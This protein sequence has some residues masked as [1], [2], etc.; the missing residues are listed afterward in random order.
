VRDQLAEPVA[1]SDSRMKALIDQSLAVGFYISLIGP[2]ILLFHISYSGF[3]N[4]LMMQLVA[5]TALSVGLYYR[6]KI[7]EKILLAGLAAVIF[8]PPVLDLIRL[9]LLTPGLISMIVMPVIV[10]SVYGMKPALILLATLIVLIVIPG[11]LHTSGTI[12]PAVN[13]QD[14]IQQPKNWITYV[15]VYSVMVLWSIVL[16]AKLSGYWQASLHDLK[17]AEEEAL[18]EREV[19]A[20]LQR[21]QSIVQLSG[22]VAHDFNNILAAITANLELIRD[23]KGNSNK[24]HI[25]DQA[26]DDAIDATERGAGLTR[27]LLAFAKVAVLEPKRL[28]LNNVVTNSIGWIR[29]TIPENIEIETELADELRAV[30]VD[31][32]SLSS[33]LLN[34]IIN[35][36][37]AMSNGGKI[38]IQTQNVQVFD[39]D[40]ASDTHELSA[41]HYIQLT[42]TD[43]G[44]GITAAEQERIFEPFY[45]TKG[46]SEGSG[47]GLAMVEG[48]MKQ[49]G[50]IVN[51]TSEPGSGARF[52]LFFP[53]HSAKDPA[54]EVRIPQNIETSD[55]CLMIVED[56]PAILNSLE[57]MMVA[58]GYQVRTAANGEQAWSVLRNNTDIDLVLSDVIMPG[59][60]QG[61]DLAKKIQNQKHNVPV[62]L[63]SGH[64]FA[65]RHDLNLPVISQVL[66]KPIRKAD[67]INAIETALKKIRVEEFV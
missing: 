33:A 9:G 13:L 16:T 26:L 42:V 60:L 48:F 20:T 23:L 40:K 22:G 41:G 6:H 38:L 17:T 36:R 12:Q 52:S 29:R 11:I 61:T 8:L 39:N 7:P 1:N 28:D 32:A 57:K 2:G 56:E 21:Q 65:H 18:R 62:V 54:P 31:E 51:L 10:S 44:T 37:D 67:L 5:C 47:L 27:N 64:T 53:A 14:F 45:S 63:M 50:G 59:P 19:V 66:S 3:S 55:V 25:V 49:T 34:L 15:A 46:P 43:S 24:T 30:Y 58:A 35:S 4:I